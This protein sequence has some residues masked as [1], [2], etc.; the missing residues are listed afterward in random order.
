LDIC[1]H[2][3]ERMLAHCY[4]PTSDL[5]DHM[6]WS[7]DLVTPFLNQV[8]TSLSVCLSFFS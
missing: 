4:Q 8:S 1:R 5:Q 2:I 3:T 6:L 7:A